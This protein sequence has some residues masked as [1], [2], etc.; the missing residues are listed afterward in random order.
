MNKDEYIIINKTAIQKRIEE[1]EKTNQI[2]RV[3]EL[4]NVLSQST[5]FISEIDKAYDAGK[6]DEELSK[7]F[8]NPKGRYL[9]SLKLDI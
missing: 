4:E 6:L 1:L 2:Q 3:D 9:S 8:D 7:M 5:S